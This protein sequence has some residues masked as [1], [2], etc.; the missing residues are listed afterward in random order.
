MLR[1]PLYLFFLIVSIVV[2]T[3]CQQK[4]MMP[5]EVARDYWNAVKSGDSSQLKSLTTNGRES[6]EDQMI[7]AIQ[8]NNFKIKRTI[9]EESNA[10]VEVDLDLAESDSIPVP[11]N[12]VLIKQNQVW[13]VDHKTTIA[14]LRSKSDI[15]DA[16]AALH[17]FGKMFS[18]DLDHSLNELERKAPV[19]RNDIKHLMEKMSKRLPTLKKEFQKLL[20]DID[21]AVK[22]LTDLDKRPPIRPTLPPRQN[23]D[24]KT[25]TL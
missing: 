7:K 20:E 10:I 14:S 2:L 24:T 22:P 25:S 11:V 8:L 3:S 16:I 18:R 19:I 13:L 1:F 23:P 4:S 17:R 21:N 9:I 15:G 12:T 5:D 6:Q